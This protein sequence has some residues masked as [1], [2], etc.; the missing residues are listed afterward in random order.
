MEIRKLVAVGWTSFVRLP[1]CL[2]EGG[3]EKERVHAFD[4]THSHTH[5]HKYAYVRTHVRTRDRA[6]AL[7]EQF[8]PK[9]SVL[10]LA[11]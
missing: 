11:H 7:N 4:G 2:P 10:V 1:F 6:H 5:T 3:R 8:I 9:H